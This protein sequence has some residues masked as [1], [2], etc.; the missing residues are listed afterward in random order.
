MLLKLS[1]ITSKC[2]NQR[3]LQ[4]VEEASKDKLAINQAIKTRNKI[5]MRFKVEILAIKIHLK[6]IAM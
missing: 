2:L 5:T 4:I 3:T 6:T 1:L